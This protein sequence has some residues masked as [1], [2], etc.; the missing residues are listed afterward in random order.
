MHFSINYPKE[1]L[2]IATQRTLQCI[3]SLK[4]FPVFF[5]PEFHVTFYF[6]SSCFRRK[7]K[8]CWWLHH[9][10]WCHHKW[11]LI[12]LIWLLILFLI[13][14]YMSF[15][16]GDMNF[17]YYLNHRSPWPLKDK[18]LVFS[19]TKILFYRDVGFGVM[20]FST[21]SA[22]KI[23]MYHSKHGSRIFSVPSFWFPTSTHTNQSQFFFSLN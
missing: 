7:Q 6:S 15:K 18:L 13:D 9:F 2:K 16:V 21:H 11:Y 23:F 5:F 12:S 22:R 14:P 10:V 3:L 19:K 20:T 1:K 17:A 8:Y 4:S